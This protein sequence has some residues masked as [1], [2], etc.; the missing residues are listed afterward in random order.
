MAE[1]G[2]RLSPSASKAKRNLLFLAVIAW[3]LAFGWVYP[4]PSDTNVS[5]GGIGLETTVGAVLGGL[6]ALLG[7]NLFS[8]WLHG[9]FGDKR[10]VESV[11]YLLCPTQGFP[12]AA[13]AMLQHIQAAAGM[14]AL[15]DKIS[16]PSQ[17]DMWLNAHSG[18]PGPNLTGIAWYVDDNKR[19]QAKAAL[20]AALHR[21]TRWRLW[22]SALRYRTA[23]LLLLEDT[24]DVWMPLIVG[25]SGLVAAA[26]SFCRLV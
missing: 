14:N 13:A 11:Y 3:A 19:R 10:N 5:L 21:R 12:A 18:E 16:G 17:L 20:W 7:Y 9:P 8:F 1:D 4:H 15:P 26:I 6:A 25:I 24:W 22:R 2:E 23:K